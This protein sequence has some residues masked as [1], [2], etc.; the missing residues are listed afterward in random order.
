[1]ASLVLE[2]GG[3]FVSGVVVEVVYLEASDPYMVV[4]LG[5]AFVL[6]EVV[7]EAAFDPYMVVVLVASFVL[8]KVDLEEAFDSI[9]VV[10]GDSL[11]SFVMALDD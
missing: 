8:V 5:A 3:N 9:V 4:A 6:V 2:E 10:L 7:L 1:M 11:D